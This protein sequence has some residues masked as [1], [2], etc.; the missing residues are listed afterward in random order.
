MDLITNKNVTNDNG[1]ESTI[2]NADESNI[3][4]ETTITIH[5]LDPL[6]TTRAM[7]N[8]A[9]FVHCGRHSRRA[10]DYK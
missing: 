3:V 2:S 10:S 7:L 5:T 9:S 1:T 4:K 6:W 8:Y